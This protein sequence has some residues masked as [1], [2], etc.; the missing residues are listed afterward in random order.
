[1]DLDLVAAGR[2]ADQ[3][4]SIERQVGIAVDQGDHVRSGPIDGGP[5]AVARGDSV[6]PVVLGGLRDVT[7]TVDIAAIGWILRAGSGRQ[8][9]PA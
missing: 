8:L 3:N 6:Q 7:L 1:M 2:D 4:V 9:N 5:Q